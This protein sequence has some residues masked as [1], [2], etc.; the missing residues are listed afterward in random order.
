MVVFNGLIDL[1]EDALPVVVVE[2]FRHG[3]EVNRS[4][5]RNL[6]SVYSENFISSVLVLGS[7]WKHFGRFAMLQTYF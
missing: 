7:V 5:S 4:V 3:E 1:C 6:S 2:A